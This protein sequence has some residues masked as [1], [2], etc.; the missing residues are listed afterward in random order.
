MEEKNCIRCGGEMSD[1]MAGDESY[2]R[3]TD[4]GF[5]DAS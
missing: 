1:G 5:I 3:C 2:K 4:C